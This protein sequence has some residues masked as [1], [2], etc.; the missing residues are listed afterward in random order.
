[1]EGLPEERKELETQRDTLRAGISNKHSVSEMQQEV[2]RVGP[3]LARLEQD[4]LRNDR[5]QTAL[6]EEMKTNDIQEA[7]SRELPPGSR[8][9]Q[10]EAFLKKRQLPHSPAKHYDGS[11]EPVNGDRSASDK[12]NV[13]QSIRVFVRND[14]DIFILKF[15]VSIDFYFDE[16]GDLLWEYVSTSGDGIPVPW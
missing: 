1:M 6:A 11:H 10:V 8:V 4:I 9:E 16:R 14:Y 5:E 7:I 3:D 13:R 15:C 12:S 2:Q